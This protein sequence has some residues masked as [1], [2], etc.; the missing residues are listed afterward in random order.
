LER[1]HRVIHGAQDPVFFL[2]LKHHLT[3]KGCVAIRFKMLTHK[4]SELKFEV[5][6]VTK[7]VEFCL[8]YFKIWSVA[9][10]QL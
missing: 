2:V 3:L 6:K 9:T 1:G 7:V 10:P 5:T 8:F 4:A